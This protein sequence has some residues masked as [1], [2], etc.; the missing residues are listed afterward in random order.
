MRSV[1]PG[2]GP[3]LM[4][5]ITGIVVAIF[6]VFW[7]ISALSMGAPLIFG[8]F[9]GMFVLIAVINTIYNFK[10]ARGKNRMSSYDITESG[11]EVDPIEKYVMTGSESLQEDSN[12]SGI[13]YCPYCGKKLENS[14]SYCTKC[15]KDIQV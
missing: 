3:S 13:S 5:G 10:N 6:G 11:E 2:R 14:Y 7:T 8:A 12:T 4:G 1:K 9:G 15:E